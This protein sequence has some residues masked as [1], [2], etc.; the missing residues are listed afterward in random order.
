MNI[1][2]QL[3]NYLLLLGVN[4]SI[5]V[6]FTQGAL[7]IQLSPY[8]GMVVAVVINLAVG[9]PMCNFWIFRK[10]INVTN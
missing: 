10:T 1:G 6:I 2:P 8:L 9:Y 5:T 7:A 3:K 4:Y